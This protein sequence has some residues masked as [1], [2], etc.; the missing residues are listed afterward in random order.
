VNA[1]DVT[2][3]RTDT[4][5]TLTFKP[6]TFGPNDSIDF[7]MS[8]FDPVEGFTTVDPDRFEGTKVTVTFDNGSTH[9]GRFAIFPKIPIDFFT[10][11]EL[12][13][14]NAAAR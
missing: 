13:N 9:T 1:G 8:V 7:G 12:V 2:F 10:G 6:G 3:S 4:T 14:A 5:M 11:A